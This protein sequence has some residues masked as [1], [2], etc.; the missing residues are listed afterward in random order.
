MNHT[1]VPRFRSHKRAVSTTLCHSVGKMDIVRYN[2]EDRVIRLTFNQSRRVSCD[3][4]SITAP[5]CE[6]WQGSRI[7]FAFSYKHCSTVNSDNRP[8]RF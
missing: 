2:L 4:P 1:H 8:P 5:T 3:A 6:A 7:H